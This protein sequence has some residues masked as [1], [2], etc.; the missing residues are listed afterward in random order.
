[1]ETKH[2]FVVVMLMASVIAGC[3]TPVGGRWPRQGV[4][5]PQKAVKPATV[6]L[7][8]DKLILS[9]TTEREKYVVGEPVYAAIRLGNLSKQPQRVV[10]SMHPEDG[11]VDIVITTPSGQ[12]KEFAPLGETDHDDSVFIELQP[13]AII[14]N[15]VPIFFGGNGWT[16]TQHGRYTITAYYRLPNGK[17]IVHETRSQS[18]AI[19]IQPSEAGSTLFSESGQVTAEVGKF[20]VWGKG[21]HL[22]KGQLKLRELTERYPNSELASY[23]HSALARNWGDAFM[24]YAKREIRPPN[25]ELALQHLSKVS[26]EK[27][28]EYVQLQGAITSAR[29]MVRAQ[30]GDA[31][32]RY[33]DIAKQITRDRPEYQALA[34]RIA[35]IDRYINQGSK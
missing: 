35:E 28:T 27:V 2:L 31:A 20:L 8:M 15:M 12:Q 26:N 5:S 30:K 14:G 7:S 17:G 23:V 22:Q 33:T 13:G 9:I 10:N 11:A 24:N 16:F 29:C 3:T 18:M 32:Q 21:D 19:E 1:M 34:A 6:V 25:C 4:V